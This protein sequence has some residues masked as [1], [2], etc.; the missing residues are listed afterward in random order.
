MEARSY[1]KI[2]YLNNYLFERLFNFNRKKNKNESFR[3][4]CLKTGNIIN[5]ATEDTVD[6]G[7]NLK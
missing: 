6:M 5:I 2:V 4:I 7:G 1:T 3:F